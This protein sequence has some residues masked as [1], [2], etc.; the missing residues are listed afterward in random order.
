MTLWLQIVLIGVYTVLVAWFFYGKGY[1][2]CE[3]YIMSMFEG[4]EDDTE[5]N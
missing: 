1:S 4:G 5:E 3:D 2:D